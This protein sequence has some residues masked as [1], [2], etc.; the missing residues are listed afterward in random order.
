VVVEL[1]DE[2]TDRFDELALSLDEGLET[3]REGSGT[4]TSMMFGQSVEPQP[5]RS[6]FWVMVFL[7]MALS[8]FGLVA[9][10]GYGY[11]NN[12]PLVPVLPSAPPRDVG[13]LPG[14]FAPPTEHEE[15][16]LMQELERN[17]P[18]WRAGGG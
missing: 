15:R 5:A 4:D 12:T 3:T 17:N 2:S 14:T 6:R 9:Y 18:G 13:R 7:A 10:F 11:V 1:N 8:A 16:Y